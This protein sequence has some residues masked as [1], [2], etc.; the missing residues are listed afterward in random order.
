M[1]VTRPR[2]SDEIARE[3]WWTSLDDEI[4]ESLGESRPLTP[5]EIGARLGISERAAASCLA[6]LATEGRVR[7]CL[8]ERT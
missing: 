2:S 3:T 7:I 1:D 8:V 4:L 6:M 5:A